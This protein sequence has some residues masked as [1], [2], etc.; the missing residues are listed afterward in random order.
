VA[1]RLLVLNDID[2]RSIQ[3]DNLLLSPSNNDLT[4]YYF[5][6]FADYLL[7]SPK[8]FDLAADNPK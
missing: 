5:T 8:T 1:K 2:K 4:A 3:H 6:F 7:L